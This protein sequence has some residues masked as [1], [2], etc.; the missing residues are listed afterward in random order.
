MGSREGFG[1][2]QQAVEALEKSTKMLEVAV[3]LMKQG[4]RAEA[5]RLRSEA[6]TQRTIS[7]LLMAEANSLERNRPALRA[8][9][10]E[11]AKPRMTSQ[12]RRPTDVTRRS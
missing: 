3:D 7:T 11:T 6:E 5:Q 1:L 4:N 12:I 8:P 10:T 9:R 2:R